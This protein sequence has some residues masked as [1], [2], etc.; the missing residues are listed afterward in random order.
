MGAVTYPNVAV[1]EFLN[2]SF[3]A[4]QVN[5]KETT[6]ETRELLRR[7]RLVW[8]PGFV[9]LDSRG[10]EIRTWVGYI[11][12]AEFIAELPVALA[13]V[14][15]LRLRHRD[16]LERLGATPHHRQTFL[17]AQSDVVVA[18]P[19]TECDLDFVMTSERL[20]E[21][22][23]IRAAMV[24]TAASGR[25]R[26]CGS[27]ALDHRGC[28]GEKARRF[29]KEAQAQTNRPDRDEPRAGGE[30]IISGAALRRAQ[31]VG[32]RGYDARLPARGL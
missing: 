17:S 31:V 29:Q 16:A 25:D 23:Q 7:Y 13:K 20:P 18:R 10:T 6:A 22:E 5:T 8:E 11:P 14:D 32:R 27:G 24:A 30:R 4:F 3:V 1:Y 9:V 21:N 12:P 19:T 26:R 2:E 15:L 28:R